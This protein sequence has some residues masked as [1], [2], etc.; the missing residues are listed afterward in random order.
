MS[1]IVFVAPLNDGTKG[2]RFRLGRKVKGLYRKRSTLKRPFGIDRKGDT[3]IA[4]HLGLRSIYIEC[5]P[6][7]KFADWVS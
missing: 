3:T 1:K 6:L 5:R 7:R 4:L 2:F